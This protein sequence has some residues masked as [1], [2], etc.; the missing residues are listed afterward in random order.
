MIRT[1]KVKCRDEKYK[2]YVKDKVFKTRHWENMYLILLLLDYK[3]DIGDFKHLTNYEIMRAVLRDNEGGEKDSDRVAYI[4][5]K[6]KDHQ[7][8]QDL[9]RGSQ[10][11][12]IHNL[13]MHMK[14]VKGEYKGFFTK[15]KR[16][17]KANAP[18]PKKLAKTTHYTLKL[19]K[20]KA[21]SF[22]K[23]KQGK[24]ELGINLDNK[25]RY[26]H[27]PVEVFT[28]LI[29][30]DLSNFACLDIQFSN[31]EIYFLI[32]YELDDIEIKP[33]TPKL[34]GLDLG[35]NNL[36]S[37]FT[38]DKNSKSLIIDGTKFKT[39]NANFNRFIA[40]LNCEIEE[41]TDKNHKRYL[42]KYRRFLY[43]KR[44]R[45][46]FDQFHK[47]SKRILEYLAKHKVTELVISDT[48]SE[49]KNNGECKQ[50]KKTKQSFIQIPFLKLNKYLKEKAPQYNIKIT[51]INEAYTSK[52]NSL[53]DDIY[54]AH[55]LLK[56]IKELNF[57]DFKEDANDIKD[58][59][60]LVEAELLTDAYKILLKKIRLS[61]KRVKRGLYVDYLND[62][63]LNSDLNG[64]YNI[65]KLSPN[66]K[67]KGGEIRQ[68][69][70]A[71]FNN[72]IKVKNDFEFRMLVK[73]KHSQV[74]A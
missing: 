70:L 37:I 1:V 50:N 53:S 45:F 8:M 21:I 42:I 51:V 15:V 74:A 13:V 10:D 30:D 22:T 67:K 12:K 20:H 17:E 26:I 25:T 7:L 9:I 47:I 5:E 52:S 73:N 29:K 69:N 36:A 59:D 4:K 64:A 66:Y 11:L 72:P 44:N 48:L 33:R 18:K 43:E 39:Y 62:N 14:K 68:L 24:D 61:G 71:K 55:S 6:Y 63:I 60:R 40:K 49:L 58:G 54:K 2:S 23:F 38:D 34:A 27:F 3:Q 57:V 35:V 65:L 32:T 19:D 46:F 28:K 41:T 31:N 56:K 16:G